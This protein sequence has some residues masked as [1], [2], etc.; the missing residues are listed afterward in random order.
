MPPINDSARAF[1]PDAA[2][3][4]AVIDHEVEFI[5]GRYR[6][7]SWP[8]LTAVVFAVWTHVSQ[9]V[10]TSIPIQ[11]YLSLFLAG[12]LVVTFTLA[13]ILAIPPRNENVLRFAYST[14]PLYGRLTLIVSL[15]GSLLPVALA[16]QIYGASKSFLAI[17]S[18]PNGYLAILF[19]RLLVCQIL[20]RK[21]T[22]L[23]MSMVSARSTVIL[24]WCLLFAGCVLSVMALDSMP[25]FVELRAMVPAL[26]PAP[27]IS[28]LLITHDRPSPLR[29]LKTIRAQLLGGLIDADSACR[30]Y[31]RET[32]T[33]L[34]ALARD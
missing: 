10:E 25:S 16:F 5:E 30:A 34:T 22:V 29:E 28:I 33:K 9:L 26:L 27:L 13:T 4:T 15:L 12:H 21:E 32:G 24:L 3:V 8:L 20:G 17:I 18:I 2:K 14:R 11:R 1:V 23:W 19:A 6:W 31:E 7:P